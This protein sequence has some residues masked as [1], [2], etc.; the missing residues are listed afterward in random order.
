MSGKRTAVALG[1]LLLSSAAAQAGGRAAVEASPA[2]AKLGDPQAAP[3][4]AASPAPP[5]QPVALELSDARGSRSFKKH[6]RR[7]ATRLTAATLVASLPGATVPAQ[8]GGDAKAITASN[9]SPVERPADGPHPAPTE[10]AVGP[11]E[12]AAPSV[13]DLV[14]KHARE[15]GVPVALAQAVVRIESRGNARASNGGALGLMQI[16]PQTARSVGFSGGASGL[17]SP[18]TNLR[19]G[20][21]VLATAYRSA[22]GDVC[23]ALLQYQSGH[24]ATHM[25]HAN[26]VY[27]S[28]ARAIMAGA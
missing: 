8:T 24:L 22:G 7:L 12:A 3:A 16:K 5:A 6:Q 9:G 23:R 1:L 11:R 20:M 14:A 28:K 21:K 27:C 4:P 13:A 15:N 17:F 10:A 25:S 19:Y 26:R 18:E 2:L